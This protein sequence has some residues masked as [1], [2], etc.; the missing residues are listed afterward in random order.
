MELREHLT[1]ASNEINQF[2]SKL[3]SFKKQ[4]ER[5]KQALVDLDTK[6]FSPLFKDDKETK[7]IVN[8]QATFNELL[9]SV[10]GQFKEIKH[11][12]A[13]K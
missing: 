7:L 6:Y 8:Q 4:Y 10:T 3:I 9:L 12:F 2:S 13:K 5:F 1:T 11:C